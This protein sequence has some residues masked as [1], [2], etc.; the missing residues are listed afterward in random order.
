MSH[1]GLAHCVVPRPLAEAIHDIF[2]L[3]LRV[4]KDHPGAGQ[5]APRPEPAQSTPPAPAPATP[6]AA[7][8]D[9]APPE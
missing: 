6:P 8:A 2:P 9:P 5:S 3:W 4:L 1:H 7:E